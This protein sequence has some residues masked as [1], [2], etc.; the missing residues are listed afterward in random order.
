MKHTD[1]SRSPSLGSMSPNWVDVRPLS[2][3]S[4]LKPTSSGWIDVRPLSLMSSSAS[5]ISSQSR[6]SLS[7]LKLSELRDRLRGTLATSNTRT[8]SFTSYVSRTSAAST[9]PTSPSAFSPTHSRHSSWTSRPTSS[10]FGRSSSTFSSD[11]K[12]GSTIT[13][14]APGWARVMAEKDD[15]EFV[16]RQTLWEDVVDTDGR[17]DDMIESL[18]DRPPLRSRRR[19]TQ[20]F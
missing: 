20:I 10:I 14:P 18:N 11:V 13:E 7:R 4:P 3:T 1:T 17:M 16:N 2:Q 15:V 6:S 8:V 12:R 5:I 9:S 19:I